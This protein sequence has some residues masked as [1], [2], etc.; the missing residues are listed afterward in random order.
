MSTFQ[1]QL[2]QHQLP[3][4]GPIFTAD[5]VEIRTDPLHFVTRGVRIDSAVDDPRTG[6]TSGLLKEGLV[7]TRVEAAVA[8]QGKYVEFS[9][10]NHPGTTLE[11][12]T[13][14]LLFPVDLNKRGS[15]GTF[16]DKVADLLIH[17]FVD[18]AL[19]EFDTAVPGEIAGLKAAMPLV[20]FE[21]LP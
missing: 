14:I 20:Q 3:G 8:A 1:Q 9:H 10:A 15:P 12:K 2:G 6:A 7:L 16:E 18:E 11:E 4:M 17:G 5:A 13:G 21:D 19:V